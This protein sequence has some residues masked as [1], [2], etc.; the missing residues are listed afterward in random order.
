MPFTSISAGWIFTLMGLLDDGRPLNQGKSPEKYKIPPCRGRKKG[1]GPAQVVSQRVETEL[2]SHSRQ[3]FAAEA[4]QPLL[5]AQVAEHR[6]N[7]ALSFDV[8]FPRCR[9]LHLLAQGILAGITLD[10]TPFCTSGTLILV[11]I[12]ATGLTRIETVSRGGCIALVAALAGQYL[13]LRTAVM[14]LLRII[15]KVTLGSN[16]SPLS[17]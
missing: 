5:I 17:A 1:H 15:L 7:H 10:P 9:L 12:T 6:F 4:V 16:Y 3:S 8:V 11:A 2:H 14:I 13:T